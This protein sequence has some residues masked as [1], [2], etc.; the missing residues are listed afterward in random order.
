M[1]QVRYMSTLLENVTVT[2][3][4]WE[5]VFFFNCNLADVTFDRVSLQNVRFCEFRHIKLK[6]LIH[7]ETRWLSIH[8]QKTVIDTVEPLPRVDLPGYVMLL[9][10][11]GVSHMSKSFEQRTRDWA[12]AVESQGMLMDFQ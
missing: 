9:G 1:S 5:N 6:K 2:D 8:L 7:R 3:C 10:R 4:R 12:R 11:V